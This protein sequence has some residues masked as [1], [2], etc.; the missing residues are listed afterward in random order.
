MPGVG[1]RHRGNEAWP[2]HRFRVSPL[3]G[4]K[5]SGC[6]P[7]SPVAICTDLMASVGGPQGK[8]DKTGSY[9]EA[10]LLGPSSSVQD[11]DRRCKDRRVP[12]DNGQGSCFRGRWS[13]GGDLD[14]HGA[15]TASGY[16]TT[17]P[18]RREQE[19]EQRPEERGHASREMTVS[20]RQA[21][22]RARQC[23][24]G[25]W[26][27]PESGWKQS[28]ALQGSSPDNLSVWAGDARSADHQDH[29]PG[30]SFADARPSGSI[31]RGATA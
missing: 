28:R 2:S 10:E 13:R 18:F 29:D 23:S 31:A 27:M 12:D 17:E 11:G 19:T 25:S 1:Q 9:R 14:E 5:E 22:G 16:Q 20:E 7:Q 6:G 21:S 26:Q 15:S 24:L 3:A 30:F 4:K 8:Q